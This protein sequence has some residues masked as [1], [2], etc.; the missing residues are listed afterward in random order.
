LILH[1]ISI[2]PDQHGV[3]GG[4]HVVYREEGMFVTTPAIVYRFI[5]PLYLTVVTNVVLYC[6]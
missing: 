4:G 1:F 2:F 5:L 6:L 3:S